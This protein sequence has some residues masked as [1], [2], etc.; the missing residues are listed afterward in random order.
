[1]KKPIG[2]SAIFMTSIETITLPSSLESLGKYAITD[3]PYNISI[4]YNG[5]V[6]EWDKVETNYP[7]HYIEKIIHCTDGDVVLTIE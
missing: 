7:G 1:M 6:A 5:T 3:T 2:S 4:R